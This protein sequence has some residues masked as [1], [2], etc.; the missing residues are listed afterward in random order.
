MPSS[1][2]R[3][4]RMPEATRSAARLC[5]CVFPTFAC[6]IYIYIYVYICGAARGARDKEEGHAVL[7]TVSVERIRFRF[8][9]RAAQARGH[10]QRRAVVLLSRP[11]I[12]QSGP[13]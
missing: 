9:E 12:R 2:V 5:S 6:Y 11:H 13:I 3:V 10:A 7:D 1:G 8:E 4:P